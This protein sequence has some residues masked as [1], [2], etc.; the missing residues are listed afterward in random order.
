MQIAEAFINEP[1]SYPGY[2]T[3][4]ELSRYFTGVVEL[5][6]KSKGFYIYRENGEDCGFLIYWKK[7]KAASWLLKFYI[8]WKILYQLPPEK[9]TSFTNASKDWED[10]EE[11]YKHV[12]EYVDVFLVCVPLSHQHTGV[13]RRMLQYPLKEAEN[14]HLMCILE[15]DSAVKMQ[16]YRSLGMKTVKSAVL[17]NGVRKFI[18]VYNEQN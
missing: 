9:L 1:G 13:F 4:K 5:G 15:T 3:L 8:S 16:K 6:V 12:R 14:E 18:M 10:Y 17:P 7:S 2:F 11:T